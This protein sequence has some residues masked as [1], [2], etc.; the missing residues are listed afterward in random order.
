MSQPKV[1]IAAEKL[2]ALVPLG[3]LDQRSF[4][5]L[6][7]QIVVESLPRGT[8]LFA[9]G[10]HDDWV[11]YLLE[12]TVELQGPENASRLLEADTRATQMPV[13]PHRPR[14]TSALA[15]TEITIL[16][17]SASLLEV[18][19]GTG[20]GAGYEIAEL[21]NDQDSIENRLLCCIFEDYMADRLSV[22]SLP[23]VAARVRDAVA[24]PNVRL[25]TV[26]RLLTAD[27]AIAAKLIRIANSPVYRG[28]QRIDNV[29]DA[30]VRFG[31]NT[32]RDIVSSVCLQG[33]FTTEF[34]LLVRAMKSTWHH[35]THVGAICHVL[36]GKAG[37]FNPDRALLA[38]LTHAIGSGALIAHAET[39]PELLR[40][41]AYLDLTIRKLGGEV[42][43]MILRKWEF[44][45]D[46]AII[47]QQCTDWHRDPGPRADYC[48]LVLMALLQSYCS[49]KQT[50]NL[51][52]M[53]S[54]PAF[55]KLNLGEVGPE[56]TLQVL[57]E[58]RAEIDALHQ[59]LAS[60]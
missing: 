51:P 23:E 31:L 16:R 17:V 25:R 38:G 13:D 19:L 53:D 46:M 10:A 42:G 5:E 45:E 14:R 55:A 56:L 47:P 29:R 1:P 30:I 20:G 28:G 43:T 2:R 7:R 58:A 11:F 34:P 6:C 36:A 4:G 18:L 33:L 60:P 44:P 49:R 40:D 24:D 3:Q 15:K 22:P 27:A 50:R 21:G 8:R 12:G 57:D 37:G 54:V 48:D 39:Y 59:T 9:Q 26:E 32:T 41:A 52:R 35:S